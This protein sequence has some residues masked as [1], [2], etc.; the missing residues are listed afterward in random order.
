[1][2]CHS[3]VR[4]YRSI[5]AQ[6]LVKSFKRLKAL[7]SESYC[8]QYSMHAGTGMNDWPINLN[9][10]LQLWRK[11]CPVDGFQHPAQNAQQLRAA[12]HRTR[13]KHL[14][15][16]HRPAHLSVLQHISDSHQQ[17]KRVKA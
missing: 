12:Q 15:H 10:R 7:A 2:R 14:A 3:I 9:D 11:K 5:K 4:D 13:P 17:N 6:V 8:P 16:A 1:M